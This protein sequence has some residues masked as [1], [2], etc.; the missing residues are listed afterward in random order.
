MKK[1]M[2]K[3]DRRHHIRFRGFGGLSW[4]LKYHEVHPDDGRSIGG[5]GLKFVHLGWGK[6]AKCL[7]LDVNFNVKNHDQTTHIMGI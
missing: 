3:G 6:H 7:F 1:T 5:S 4:W 2:T